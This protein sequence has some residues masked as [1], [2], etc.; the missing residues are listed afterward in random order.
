MRTRISL[1]IG[2]MLG[3]TMM[4][5]CGNGSTTDKPAQAGEG[6]ELATERFKE[7]DALQASSHPSAVAELRN[8]ATSLPDVEG[9]ERAIISLAYIAVNQPGMSPSQVQAVEDLLVELSLD[10][11][12][13][14]RSAALASLD[15]VR[16]S[17]AVE[18]VGNLYIQVEGEVKTG[19]TITLLLFPTSSASTLEGRVGI[20][21]IIGDRAGI[22][23]DVHKSVELTIE[24]NV[25]QVTKIQV[26]LNKPGKYILPVGLKLTKGDGE[27]QFIAREVHLDVGQDNGS[28]FIAIPIEQRDEIN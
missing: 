28:Y 20:G 18:E 27:Q 24:P 13:V 15:Q 7:I 11:E 1:L 14:I 17:Q 21:E 10:E 9:R 2:L 3:A 12:P 23:T 16:S 22:Q 5:G 19:S 26:A 8:I 4:F 25:A 6:S